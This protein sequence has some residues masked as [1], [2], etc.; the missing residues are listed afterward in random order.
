MSYLGGGNS[1][2]FSAILGYHAVIVDS[3]V[4]SSEEAIKRIKEIVEKPDMVF[5]DYC[6]QLQILKSSISRTR[7]QAGN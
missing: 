4:N 6:P 1:H 5:P 7:N 2:S 3:L